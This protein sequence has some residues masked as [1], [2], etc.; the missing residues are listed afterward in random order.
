M[1]YRVRARFDDDSLPVFY[2]KLTDGTIAAQKPDGEEIVASMKRAVITEP[3]I[4]EWHETCYCDAPLHHERTTQ[5]DYYFTDITTQEVS[6]PEEI[7]GDS[8]WAYMQNSC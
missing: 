3:D 8:F 1:L 5:Y 6:E 4:V 2:R 7:S